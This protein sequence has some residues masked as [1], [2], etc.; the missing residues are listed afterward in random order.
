[1]DTFIYIAI[2][3]GIFVLVMIVIAFFIHYDTIYKI[4]YN[5]GCRYAYGKGHSQNIEKA[6]RWFSAAEKHDNV[7]LG[8]I[9][10]EIGNDYLYGKNGVQQNEEKA[11]LWFNSAVKRNNNESLKLGYYY[12]YGKG[13]TQD[14]EKAIHWFDVATN[15]DNV[16]VGEILF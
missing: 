13:F 10:F 11:V 3:S 9:L 8:N 12:A 6:I 7:K 16:K 15:Q 5:I 4:R 14:K 2:F 1:M